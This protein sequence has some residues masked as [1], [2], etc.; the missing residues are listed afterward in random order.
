MHLVKPVGPEATAA[1][2]LAAL[3][4]NSPIARTDSRVSDLAARTSPHSR[5][6]RRRRRQV[7]VCRQLGE[8][9]G[10]PVVHLDRHF[11]RAGWKATPTAE[12]NGTVA[13]L[14]AAPEWI[15]DGNFGGSLAIRGPRCDAVVFF[16]FPRLICLWGVLKRW[17][18][19]RGQSR[20]DMTEGC[21]DAV[22]LEFLLWIWRYPGRSSSANAHCIRQGGTRCRR[23]ARDEPT[24]VADLLDAAR[25]KLSNAA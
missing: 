6:R 18:R 8:L 19:F 21:P 3:R 2:R 11:W 22:S 15:M 25:R 14:A 12:W 5:R 9:T 17:L 10:L 23:A 7:D 4:S 1:A 16:D 20:P 13:Q 24:D